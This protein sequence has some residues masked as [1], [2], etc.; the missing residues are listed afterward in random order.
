MPKGKNGSPSRAKG[1]KKRKTQQ[2]D[3]ARNKI[4]VASAE[5]QVQDAEMTVPQQK[6]RRLDE[7]T[8]QLNP[9][10]SIIDFSQNLVSG[11][12]Q[13]LSGL[14]TR[15]SNSDNV[16]SQNQSLAPESEVIYS[17]NTP[18]IDECLYDAVGSN[19]P[20]KLKEKIWK[21]EF[22]D[23]CLLIKSPRELANFPNQDGELVVRGGRMKVE[24]GPSRPLSNIH[25]W[26]SAFIVYMSVML[27]KGE[28]NRH[29]SLAQELLKYMRDI[30]FAASKSLGWVSYDEQFRLRKA[31]KPQ[32][33][34][35]VI[36]QDLWAFYIST[37]MRDFGG[38]SPTN[39]FT[40][41]GMAIPPEPTS[42]R[43][44]SGKINTPSTRTCNAYN[45]KGKRC[46]FNPCRFRHVC[47]GCFGQHP[48]YFCM[49][50]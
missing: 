6:I 11:E 49:R 34:W 13:F 42:F 18:D 21:Q 47:S 5:Q 43:R 35:G 37:N 15:Q 10:E 28:H 33:S 39:N 32:S 48:V 20:Q 22:I 24:S 23:L 19:I 30:R 45:T 12:S 4:T 1:V 31:R 38:Q 8:T 41:Q 50:R 17:R 14:Y 27:E 16:N 26:T 2:Q 9:G 29:V 7:A 44:A 3:G 40:M 46:N 25:I 36:N